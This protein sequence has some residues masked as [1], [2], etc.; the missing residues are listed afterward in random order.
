MDTIDLIILCGYFFFVLAAAFIFRRFSKSASGFI[1]GGGAMMWWMAGAT[2][3]MTQFS[4]WTFTGAAAKAYEDGLTVLFLFWGNAL[5]F[6]VASWYFAARFRKLRVDTAMEVIRQRFGKHS[7]QLFTWLQFPL[8]TLSAAIWLNGLALFIAAVLGV[9]LS[10]T[11]I[12]VG[13]LVTVIA[14]SGGSWTVS[15]TNTMQLILLMSV[16]MIAGLFALI[17]A[18][19][20]AA[21]INNFPVNPVMGES[22][23]YWQ[24][25]VVWV[26]IIMMKQTISTNNAMTCYRFPGHNQ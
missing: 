14:V 1:R 24:I 16:T 19:G 26:V 3:F 15:A 25:F 17:Q 11:I 23:R 13:V 5:G 21:I 6:F 20:P 9:N 18:G 4:A 22:I 10:I 7:E 8:T 12:G 2:A